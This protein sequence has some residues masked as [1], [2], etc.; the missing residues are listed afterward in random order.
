MIKDMEQRDKGAWLAL[1][2]GLEEEGKPAQCCTPQHCSQTI[3][4]SSEG[5]QNIDSHVLW[6]IK[7][8][9]SW[10]GLVYPLHVV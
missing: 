2:E 6:N 10:A 1:S 8:G 7:P 5:V 4:L 3:R 9:C